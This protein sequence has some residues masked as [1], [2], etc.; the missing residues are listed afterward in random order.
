MI[1]MAFPA[2]SPSTMMFSMRSASGIHS[3]G[4]DMAI[5]DG[6]NSAIST[7]MDWNGDDSL[8]DVVNFKVNSSGLKVLLES[9]RI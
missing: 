4:A 1:M 7:G 8:F 9:P 3:P 2:V 6:V 5:K